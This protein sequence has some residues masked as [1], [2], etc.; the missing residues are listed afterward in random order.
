MAI[1]PG[2]ISR[3]WLFD[4]EEDDH[5]ST[6]PAALLAQGVAIVQIDGP[7]VQRGSWC[8][9]GYA[10]VQERFMRATL[11]PRVRAVVLRLNSPG[12]VV[13]GLFEACRQM[14]AIAT[15]AGVPVLAYADERACSA[16]YALACVADEIWLPS[17]GEVGSVGIIATYFDETRALELEGVRAVVLV[18]GKCKADGNRNVPITEEM[19]VRLR[20]PVD[21][22]AEQFAAWVAERR[23][24]TPAAVL[25]Q[26]AAV[27]MGA[28]AL[29]AKLADRVGS[30]SECLAVALARAQANKSPTA[31]AS[32]ERGSRMKTV[33][34]ALGLS[35][36]AGEAEALAAVTALLGA[37]RELVA[38]TGMSSVPEALGAVQGLCETAR[39]HEALV[40][41]VRK[42]REASRSAA[43]E[44]A[45]KRARDEGRLTAASEAAFRAQFAVSSDDDLARLTALLGALPVVLPAGEVRQKTEGAQV[46]KPWEELSAEE[47]HR[48]YNDNPKAYR[49]LKDDH[50][51]RS[52]GAQSR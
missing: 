46:S 39:A 35:E 50:A 19:I 42:E 33:L 43:A 13:S 14:R 15:Q 41:Q 20:R 22:L 12:G 37:Q 48:L 49:A 27:W 24:M 36:E 18:S 16:A 34:V 6:T 44:E 9:D 26:E 52:A 47:K 38:I 25:G 21:Q 8:W 4:D 2:A 1:E 40:A 32:A 23:R 7:L 28:E 10:Q 45:Y 51:R 31:R 29:S 30:L 5:E 11:D 17:S 3:A